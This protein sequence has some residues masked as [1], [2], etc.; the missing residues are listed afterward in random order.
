MEYIATGYA[1]LAVGMIFA[2]D[3]KKYLEYKDRE[4]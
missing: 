4:E 2:Y 3:F 1:I